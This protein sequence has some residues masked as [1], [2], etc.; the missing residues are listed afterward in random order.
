M[1]KHPKCQF[2]QAALEYLGHV[3]SRKGVSTDPMKIE[4][5]KNWTQ[6]KIIR[7]LRGFLGRT[8]YNHG[9]VPHYDILAK[10]LATP[11]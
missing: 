10:P 6:P 11:L 2:V 3:I 1:V 9:F 7:A 5:I 8:C 4:G